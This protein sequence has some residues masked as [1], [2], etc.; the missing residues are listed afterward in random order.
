[1]NGINPSR[2]KFTFGKSNVTFQCNG[3]HIVTYPKKHASP[4]S[5]RAGGFGGYYEMDRNSPLSS[6]AYDLIIPKDFEWLKGGKLHGLYFGDGASGGEH[7]D[8]GGSIRL[9]WRRKGEVD[10]YLYYPG[11]EKEYGESNLTN[12]FLQEWLNQIKIS[13]KYPTTN[14]SVNDQLYTLPPRDFKASCSGIFFST[15]YGG[16]DL[17]WAPSKTQKL[18]F[19]NIMIQ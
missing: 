14:I 12:I 1:M 11:L 10:I 3:D 19:K 2:I 6:L 5:G 17:S 18:E 15:F 4:A 7:P 8:R 13:Y 9:M 16:N